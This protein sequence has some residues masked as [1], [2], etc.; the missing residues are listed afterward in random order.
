MAIG[1][2]AP[3]SNAIRI[4]IS[5]GAGIA[6]AVASYSDSVSKVVRDAAHCENYERYASIAPVV[7][8]AQV[9]STAQIL[10]FCLD[11]SNHYARLGDKCPDGSSLIA[12]ATFQIFKYAQHKD[13]ALNVLL[14]GVVVEVDSD[15]F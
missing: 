12:R 8:S 2:C 6:G 9:G 1:L 15:E 3:A 13:E 5:I 4:A 11:D 7:Q 10:K 14:C